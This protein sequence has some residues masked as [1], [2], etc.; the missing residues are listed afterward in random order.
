MN[1]VEEFNKN[2]ERNYY[3]FK[4]YADRLNTSSTYNYDDLLHRSYLKCYNAIAKGNYTG[5]TYTSYTYVTIKNTYLTMIRDT[6]QYFD[7]TEPTTQAY[8]EKE[9]S[10]DNYDKQ[11]EILIMSY[12]VNGLYDFVDK[13]YDERD[14]YLFRIYYKLNKK[15]NYKQLSKISGVSITAVSNCIKKIKQDLN[16]NYKYFVEFGMKKEEINYLMEETKKT[17]L[18]DVQNHYDKYLSIHMK[19]FGEPYKGCKCTPYRLKN[20]V[21]QWLVSAIVQYN[22]LN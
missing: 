3:V 12:L 17:L 22:K 10:N 1:N 2:F 13:Y 5:N 14:S 18:M 7:I 21:Q 15:I 8:V 6:K 19:I 9:L 16:K 4:E 20:K 11:E